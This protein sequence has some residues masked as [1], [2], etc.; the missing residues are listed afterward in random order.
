MTKKRILMVQGSLQAGGAEKA[1]VSLLNTLSPERYDVDLMLSSRTGLFYDQIPEWV[2]IIDAPFPYSCLA[3]KPKEWRFYI[4]HPLMWLKKIKRTWKGKHQHLLHL[5]QSLWQQWRNDIPVFERQYDVAYGGQEGMNN[6]YVIDKV[7]A[8]RKIVW[9]HNDYD[10]LGYNADF[11]KTYFKK[12]TIVATMSPEA[13]RVL[14]KDFPEIADHVWFLEN[15]TNGRMIHRMAEEPVDDSSFKVLDGDLN[16]ISVGRLAPMKNFSRALHAASLLKAK[17][18]AFHWTVVGEGGQRQELETLRHTLGLDENFSFV[19]L[20]ANPY[21]YMAH[22][23]MLVVSSDFEGRSISIDEAQILGLPV[24]TTDYDT[25]PDAVTDGETGLICKM[26]PE[27]IAESI[28]RLWTDKSLY[29]RIK[30]TLQSKREGNVREIE[31]YY[32]AFEGKEL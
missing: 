29:N 19:G 22:A 14:Q 12:A 26:S 3:H 32:K 4:H 11:D 5:M 2:N 8:K 23:D 20:R 21:K 18:I 1:M 15:I 31:K 6:Y 28:I 10:K 16:I 9:I 7:R 27:G 17:G 25:A 13:K 30:A 24:I